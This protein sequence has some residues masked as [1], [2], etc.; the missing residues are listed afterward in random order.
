MRLEKESELMKDE[1]KVAAEKVAG[2]AVLALMV[3]HMAHMA[4][5][6]YDDPSSISGFGL[7][8]FGSFVF[9]GAAGWNMIC[10]SGDAA[11]IGKGIGLVLVSCV[12]MPLFVGSAI[13]NEALPAVTSYMASP[14]N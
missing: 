10:N 9:T 2:V 6:I 5:R 13:V 1:M 7:M 3:A 14:K 4:Q 11:G 12:S 8:V